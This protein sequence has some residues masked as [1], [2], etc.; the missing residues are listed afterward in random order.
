[1]VFFISTFLKQLLSKNLIEKLKI[2][3]EKMLNVLENCLHDFV[4]FVIAV[5]NNKNVEFKQVSKIF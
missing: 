3:L 4:Y 5:K 1:M 2:L